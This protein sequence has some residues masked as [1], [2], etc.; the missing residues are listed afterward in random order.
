MLYSSTGSSP[1][2]NALL[3]Q[4][5]K[6]SGKCD[7]IQCNPLQRLKTNVISGYVQRRQSGLKSGGIGSWFE[8]GGRGPKSSTDESTRVAPD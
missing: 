7:H 5:P 2:M 8:N 1:K 4:K 6:T 3:L